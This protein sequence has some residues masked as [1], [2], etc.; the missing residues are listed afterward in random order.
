M[1]NNKFFLFLMLVVLASGCIVPAQLPLLTATAAGP[2]ATDTLSYT[3]TPPSTPVD[4]SN[5]P[6]PTP[7]P[8]TGTIIPHPPLATSGPYLVYQRQEADQAAIIFLDADGKG[9]KRFS[10]PPNAASENMGLSLSNI[11]SPDG[12]WL[13]YYSGSAGQCFGNGT[14]NSADLS[15]NLMSLA[16][17]KTQVVTQLLSNDYPNNFAKAAQELNPSNI[18]ADQLQNAFVCGITQSIAW[19]PDGH[20]L[21]FAGQMD[22]LSSDLYTYDMASQAIKRLSSGPEEVQM[23]AWSPDGQWILDWS[24]YESGEGMTY[25]LYATS[26]DGSVIKKLPVS[27]CDTARWLDDQTCFSSEDGNGI[28]THNLSLLNI[29]TGDIVPVWDGEFSSLAVSDDHQWIAFVSRFSKKYL[30]TGSD[31]NFIPGIYL[32]NLTTFKQNRVE[33]PDNSHDYR[34]IQPLGNGGYMF[35]LIDATENNLY[36]LSEEGKLTPAGV[37][38]HTFSVAPDKKYLVAFGDKVH[39]LTVNGD[40]IRDA[41]LPVDVKSSDIGSILWQPDSS[42]LF[43]F[44]DEGPQVPQNLYGMDLLTGDPVQVDVGLPTW[45]WFPFDFIWVAQSK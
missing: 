32:V 28:G 17:G 26:L 34:W 10:Y 25:N 3:P 2:A 42:G 27:S 20:T 14:P 19:S 21:A 12:K 33:V 30:Q 39:V 43:F 23:I 40:F 4:L 9:Q 6:A 7:T 5:T 36:F 41:G 1:K 24:S 44:S 16:D 13:A 35:A 31:P 37:N 15:L 22:G 8:P 18:T 11:L 45:W 38:A 29:K